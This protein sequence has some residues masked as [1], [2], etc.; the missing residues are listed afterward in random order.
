MAGPGI[1]YTEPVS[2]DHLLEAEARQLQAQ[3]R[4]R[5]TRT[6]NGIGC[7]RL[8]EG[9]PILSFASNDYLG[10]SHHPRVVEAAHRALDTWGTGAT[11]ARLITGNQGV[12]QELEE[13]LARFLG[14]EGVL[15]FPS[16]YQANI[17]LLTAL[18]SKEDL[19]VSDELNH[20]SLID[21]C[22]LSRAEVR[23]FRH[24]N[25]DH[26][27]EILADRASAGHRRRFLVTESLFSMDGDHAPLAALA[28]VAAMR[29]AHLLVDEAHALGTSGPAGRGLCASAGVQ[30]A[31]I[32]ATLGK[33]LG[34]QGAFVAGSSA[35][36][37]HLVNHARPFIFTTAPAPAAVAAALAALRIL[38][39]SEGASLVTR[40]QHNGAELRQAITLPS[41]GALNSP[42]LPVVLGSEARALAAAEHLFTAGLYVPAIRP[43]TVPPGSC[44]L[45]ITLSAEH[46]PDDLERLATAL[47]SQGETP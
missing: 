21:G 10:L 31:A 14:L 19:I 23:V 11:G 12:H 15:L 13:E 18:A 16:G 41:R 1:P 7:A 4:L 17:G 22:R 26:A 33:A 46:T 47:A 30:P 44:R 37:R 34:A 45:R 9:R 3:G 40:L 35:L 36:R 6:L 39:S 43:P 27:D 32:T 38:A 8:V 20:A 24:G 28:R 2:L 5:A 25:A 42:I 29:G